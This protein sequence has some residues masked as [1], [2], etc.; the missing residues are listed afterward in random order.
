MPRDAHDIIGT[1]PAVDL[2]PLF[3]HPSV[4]DATAALQQFTRTEPAPAPRARDESATFATP[5]PLTEHERLGHIERIKRAVLGPLLDRALERKDRPHEQ[6]PGVTAEDVRQ[7]AAARQLGG[8][9]GDQQ[10]AWSWLSGWLQELARERHLVKYRITGMTVKRM[11]VNGNDQ[12][13]YLHPYD[14]RAQEAA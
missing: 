8:L 9:L 7:L 1:A 3:A 14:Y 13:V 11:A 10:R 4:E 12:V 2:G 6:D 5:E